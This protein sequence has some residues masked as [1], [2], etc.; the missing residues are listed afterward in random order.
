MAESEATLPTNDETLS[1]TEDYTTQ[2]KYED[3]ESSKK[4]S[5]KT[6]IL[7]IFQF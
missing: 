4:Q 7:Y 3:F 6:N 1:P 5:G 2:S